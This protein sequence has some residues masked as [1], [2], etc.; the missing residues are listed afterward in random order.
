MESA[1]LATFEVIA[2]R[3]TYTS[4]S[5]PRSQMLYVLRVDVSSGKHPS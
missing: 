5:R 1:L 2:E 3:I 4:S